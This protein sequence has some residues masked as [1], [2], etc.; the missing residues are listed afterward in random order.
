MSEAMLVVLAGAVALFMATLVRAEFSPD[1]RAAIRTTIVAVLGWFFACARYGLKPWADLT[2]QTKWMLALSAL[3]I[4][5]AW[6]FYFRA[7][8]TKTV[9]R[10]A[11]MDRVNIGLAALFVTLL[12]LQQMSAQSALIGVVL[13]GGT[14]VLAFGSR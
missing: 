5:L 6:L 9:S 11:A 14:L 8:R 3:A 4:I 12:L 13:I 7:T 1:L 2:W 10:V